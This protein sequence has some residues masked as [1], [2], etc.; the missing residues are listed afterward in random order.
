L[1]ERSTK[2]EKKSNDIQ[3]RGKK[4]EEDKDKGRGKRERFR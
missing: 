1:D 4:I 2:E 3:E